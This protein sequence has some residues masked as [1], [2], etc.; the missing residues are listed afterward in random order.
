M[1]E[2]WKHEGL[3]STLGKLAWIFVLI[4]GIGGI[5]YTITHIG[6][7]VSRYAG[8]PVILRPIMPFQYIW[9]IIWSIV[10]MILAIVVIKPKFS[11]RC[12]E[13]DWEGLYGWYLKLGNTKIPWMLIWGIILSGFSWWNWGGAFI[14]IPTIVLLAAG[15]RK[16]EWK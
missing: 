16:Y 13:K 10:V 12:S 2:E 11:K 15:P 8:I 1:S 7:Y 5:F 9:Y 6:I 14:L 3:V 4:N